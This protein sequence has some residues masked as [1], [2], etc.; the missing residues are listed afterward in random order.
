[1]KHRLVRILMLLTLTA[2]TPWIC[3]N[4]LGW[5]YGRLLLGKEAVSAEFMIGWIFGFWVAPIVFILGAV[6]LKRE[7]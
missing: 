4:L 3:A 7:G 6:Y 5:G 1:M 2:L